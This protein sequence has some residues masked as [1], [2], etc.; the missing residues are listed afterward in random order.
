MGPQ[1][2][3]PPVQYAAAPPPVVYQQP[4]PVVYAPPPTTVIYDNGP[5]Y[6]G[7]GGYGGRYGGGGVDPLLAG[8]LGFGAGMLAG[9]MMGGFGGN[10]ITVINDGFGDTTI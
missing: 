7:Y 2:V 1:T 10:D 3:P 8:G 6:G 9:E 5:R 4:A